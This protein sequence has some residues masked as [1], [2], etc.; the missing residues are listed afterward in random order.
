VPHA[1]HFLERLDRVPRSLTDFA[2]GLYRD[3][4]RVKWILHYAHLPKE[5]E[6]V[7]LALADG[8]DGPYIVV[9]R[10][11]RFVTA[12]GPGMKPS[13]LTVL[14]RAQVDV[15]SARVE[16]ARKRFELAAEVVAPGK[17][18]VDMLGLLTTRPWRLTR[19]EFAAIARVSSAHCIGSWVRF[20]AKRTAP[21]RSPSISARVNVSGSVVPS[22]PP[23]MSCPHRRA[24]AR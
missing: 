12:L 22:N 16:D 24:S 18:P 4:A 14:S 21:P 9:T 15:F 3:E 17:R 10:E 5:E 20:R 23:T 2:L 1:T 13:N 11:G 19:D 6:R 7:A 8:G